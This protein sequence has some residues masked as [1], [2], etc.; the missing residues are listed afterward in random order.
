[1]AG[2]SHKVGELQAEVGSLRQDLEKSQSLVRHLAAKRK[3]L[4]SKVSELTREQ[5]E[6]LR[7]M[8]RLRLALG[9]RAVPPQLERRGT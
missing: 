6:A 7:E 9:G 3:E 8:L 2:L 5:R 4:E 1:M